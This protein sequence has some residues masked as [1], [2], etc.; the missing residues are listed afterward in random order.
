MTMIRRVEISRPCA[1][2]CALLWVKAGKSEVLVLVAKAASWSQ[3]CGWNLGDT[4]PVFLPEFG[5]SYL[6][7]KT[8]SSVPTVNIF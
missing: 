7:R 6:P 1:F 8:P 3:E 5:S 2:E 4:F